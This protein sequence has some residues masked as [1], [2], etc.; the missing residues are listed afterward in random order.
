MSDHVGTIAAKR[1]CLDLKEEKEV[2]AFRVDPICYCR[3][4]WLVKLIANS[5]EKATQKAGALLKK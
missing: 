2:E 1:Y 3:N 5:L 4:T